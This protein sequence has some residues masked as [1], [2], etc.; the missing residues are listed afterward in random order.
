MKRQLQLK[1]KEEEVTTPETKA[2][3]KKVKAKKSNNT[4]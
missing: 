3:A 2:P 4:N 1:T